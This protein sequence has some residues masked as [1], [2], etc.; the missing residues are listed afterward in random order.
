[1]E[2]GVRYGGIEPE[3]EA[4]MRLVGS[5]DLEKTFSGK[6]LFAS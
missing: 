5:S 4:A 6:L 3:V 2:F 1:L